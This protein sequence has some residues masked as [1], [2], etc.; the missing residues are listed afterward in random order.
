[1]ARLIDAKVLE[2]KS[3]AKGE[4]HEELTRLV[5]IVRRL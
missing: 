4:V 1:M 3:Q 2:R 5:E